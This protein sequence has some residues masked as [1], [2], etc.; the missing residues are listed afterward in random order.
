[1]NSHPDGLVAALLD[2]ERAPGRYPVGLREPKVLF[3]NVLR[4]LQLAA[5]RRPAGMQAMLDGQDIDDQAMHKAARFFVR[6]A[7]LRPGN[8]HVALMGLAPGYTAEQLRE[9]YRLL[10]RMT[11]PDFAASDGHAQWTWPADAAQRINLANDTLQEELLRTVPAGLPTTAVVEP[12]VQPVPRPAPPAKPVRQRPQWQNVP[13]ALKW[14]LAGGGALACL[15]AL[16]LLDTNNDRGKLAAR[17]PDVPVKTALAPV[18]TEPTPT[19][20]IEAPPE[21][22]AEPAPPA[23][24][25]ASASGRAAPARVAP[26]RPISP[27]ASG[28]EAPPRLK[29]A[30]TLGASPHMP[31]AHT[32]AEAQID[33]QPPPQAPAPPLAPTI[34]LAD[35]QPLLVHLMDGIRTGRA[36][37]LVRWVDPDWRSNPANEVFSQHFDRMLDGRQVAQLGQVAFKSKHAGDELQVDGSI[38]LDL[39]D[40]VSRSEKRHLQLRVYF[41]ERDGKPILTKLVAEHL[42]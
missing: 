15:G 27:G 33:L 6:T 14:T 38:E 2:F 16:L 35:A 21:V 1:M 26:E 4:V 41:Q 39:R 42:R 30:A 11:H 19:V 13:A 29:M 40:A 32:P 17:K 20:T 3:D 8:D 18:V 22:K 36:Q 9:H 34:T 37:S 28:A 24:P 31:A 25:K 7:L 10:I 23:S 12:L 5:G